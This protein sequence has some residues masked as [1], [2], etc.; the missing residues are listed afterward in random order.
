MKSYVLAIRLRR[1]ACQKTG[2]KISRAAPE[3]HLIQVVSTWYHVGIDFVGPLTPTEEGYCYILTISDYFSK[4]V[5]A[6]AMESKHASGV[7]AALFKV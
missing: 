4:F 7:A 2:R 5:Q 6:F 1:D 3:L